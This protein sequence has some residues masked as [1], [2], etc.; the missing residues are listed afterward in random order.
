[1]EEENLKFSGILLKPTH[2][3]RTVLVRIRTTSI[4]NEQL[5]TMLIDLLMS[6]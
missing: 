4:S 6:L 2:F 1:M 5:T 3:V